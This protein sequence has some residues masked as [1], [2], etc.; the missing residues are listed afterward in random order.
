MPEQPYFSE[1]EA[2]PRPR[3]VETITGPL[4][5]GIAA[6][7]E[8]RVANGSFGED[9]PAQCS[10]GEG[11]YATDANLFAAALRAE[12]PGVHW[13]ANQYAVPETPLAC[14]IIEFCHRHVSEPTRRSY[15]SFFNH[16]HLAFEREPG[17]QAFRET[18]N[19][20][21]GRNGVALR[22]EDNGLVQRIPPAGLQ[23]L[24]SISSFATGDSLLD[25]LLNTACTKFVDPDET[26]RRDAVE[27]LWDAWE[28]L[29]TLD[30][31]DK[32]S[33]A[34]TILDRAAAEPN[35]RGLLENEALALTR[36]GNR[37]LIRHSETTQTPIA[38]TDQ[39]DYLFHRLFSLVTLLLRSRPAGP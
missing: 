11:P 39:V 8:M 33:S 19:R 35:F 9:F 25:S 36:I 38:T 5:A 17:Q 27:K 14:D 15:H 23:E 6:Q 18:M 31:A 37:F 2:G 1:R 20:I 21:L 26:T 22:L 28:R 10:D 12:N 16:H 32:K 13:P 4:W 3:T 24:L 30:G 34:T 7:I 29:K